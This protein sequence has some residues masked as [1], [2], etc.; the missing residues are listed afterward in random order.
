MDHWLYDNWNTLWTT[1]GSAVLIAL[2]TIV[3]A[4]IYG[5]RSFAKMTAID[6]VSSVAIGSILASVVMNGGTS[7][8]QGFVAMLVI[9]GVQNLV[10]YL[11]IAYPPA[12]DVIQN[13][14]QLLMYRGEIRYETMNRVGV[15]ETDLMAKLREANVLKLSHVRAVIFETT[16]DVS[17]LHDAD[18]TEVDE[19]ILKGVDM[20]DIQV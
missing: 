10:S 7:I 5:L 20:G 13:K 15:K 4:R 14:P 3:V 9:I 6:F 12:E 2:A 16:G 11:K 17:V 8:L 1:A 18:G 19:M